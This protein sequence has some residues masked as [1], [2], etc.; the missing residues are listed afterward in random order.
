[1]SW[2][3]RPVGE[4]RR[5]TVCFETGEPLHYLVFAEDVAGFVSKEKRKPQRGA[6]VSY[7]REVRLLGPSITN[8]AVLLWDVPEIIWESPRERRR[9]REAEAE[10]EAAAAEDND[11]VG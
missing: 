8:P 5:V 9:R 7:I 2:R 3:R 10:T 4:L 6:K 11:S 1:M